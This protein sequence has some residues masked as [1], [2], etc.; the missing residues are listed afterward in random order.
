MR[1]ATQT[2]TSKNPHLPHIQQPL[3]TQPQINP[4]K[5]EQSAIL[6]RSVLPDGDVRFVINVGHG[7]ATT[8]QTVALE[9]LLEIVTLQLLHDFENTEF[10]QAHHA[11]EQ[12]ANPRLNRRCTPGRSG[13]S[14]A[15]FVQRSAGYHG[16]ADDAISSLQGPL[17]RPRGVGTFRGSRDSN[18]TDPGDGRTS[19]TTGSSIPMSDMGV[20][21]GQDAGNTT[22][23]R[24]R[25]PRQSSSG[26][27]HARTTTLSQRRD[28]PNRLVNKTST[29]MTAQSSS[30]SVLRHSRKSEDENESA[31]AA[32]LLRQ[33]QGQI[34]GSSQ[35]QK[36]LTEVQISE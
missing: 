3:Y 34:S 23:H 22:D 27:Q 16:G 9:R 29:L 1:P 10:K 32:M 20:C 25:Q 2:Q 26:E 33:F 31:E 17:V 8:H 13:A 6:S 4:P 12:R 11:A 30:V 5:V 15:R 28:D 18:E 21:K 7:A 36:P 24:N 19:D 35:R 14:I